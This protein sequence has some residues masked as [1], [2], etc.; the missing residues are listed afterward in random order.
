M[1][2][3][4]SLLCA[5]LHIQVVDE[6]GKAIWTRLE[7]RNAED[8]PYAAPGAIRDATAAKRLGGKP[9][10]RD[11][12]V[13]HGD[14]RLEVPAGRYRIVAEHGL[15]YERHEQSLE[16][17]ERPAQ[18]R[19]TLKP[20]IRM[21]KRGW[22]SG[23]LHV[24]RPVNDMRALVLA[25]DVN[26]SASFTMWNR[27]S[28]GPAEHPVPGPVLSAS[29]DHLISL[30]NAEDEREGGAWML[31]ALSQ[32]PGWKEESGWYP[33]GLR[34]VRWARSLRAWFDCEKPTWWEVPVMMAVATPDSFG[35]LHN[36]F[37]QYGMLAN[38]AWGRKRDPARFPGNAGFVDYSLGLHYRYWNLGLR[39]ALSAGSASG[40]LPNPV[41]YNRVYVPARGKLSVDSWYAALRQRRGFVTNGPMLFATKKGDR[42]SIEAVAREPI[43]RVD[44]VAN[45]IVIDTLIPPANTKQLKHVFA[46]P[47]ASHSW[48]AV[49]CFL[50]TTDTIRLAHSAPF[51]IPGTWDARGDAAFFVDWIDELV[52]ATPSHAR[53]DAERKELLDLYAEAREFYAR[54]K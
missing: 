54:R 41:G 36:H 49:R 33:P 13:V 10:Y 45:G 4:V 38:E 5:Q 14:A 30:M 44:L 23:D 22:W 3:L 47:K 25:E 32:R 52:A 17:D 1:A 34:Y 12:F 46:L 9:Y 42:L 21:R 51:E 18:V 27:R 6:A 19:V 20:W 16:V 53:T 2:F 48:V 15:E 37:N 28:G 43:A 50:A 26:F 24:H 8:K 29:P 11:S 40:V 35:L 7:V 39:P 31:H